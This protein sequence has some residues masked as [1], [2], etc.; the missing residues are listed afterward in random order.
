MAEDDG[1]DQGGEQGLDEVPG[2]TQDGLF[3]LG[4]KVAVDEEVDQVAIAPEFAELEVEEVTVG[5]DDLGPCGLGVGSV[6]GHGGGGGWHGALGL[7]LMGGGVG[8]CRS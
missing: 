6:Q 7:R 4:D 1:E 5:L 2:R 8:E 3:V